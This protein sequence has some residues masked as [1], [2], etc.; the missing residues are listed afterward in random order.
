MIITG[1]HKM[2]H[3]LLYEPILTLDKAFMDKVR[4]YGVPKAIDGVTIKN[5][6]EI[7]LQHLILA[8]NVKTKLDLY[9][10]TCK[11]YELNVERID[12]FGMI[13]FLR[14]TLSIEDLTTKAF[15][16][17]KTLKRESKDAAIKDILAKFE[18][19]NPRAILVEIMTASNGAY[20]QTQAG[21]LPWIM[22][23]DILE[24]QTLQYDKEMAISELQEKRMKENGT[25]RGR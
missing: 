13:D 17:F 20:T 25:K 3:F 9:T 18:R 10:V 4:A 14:L 16:M 21:E 5:M 1:K 7:Q 6:A 24:Q 12:K 23:Y 11:A 2:S 22:A 15:E 19:S 8:W